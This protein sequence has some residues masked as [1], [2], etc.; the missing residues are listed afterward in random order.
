MWPK[1][2]QTALC[3]QALAMVTVLGDWKFVCMACGCVICIH[4]HM[5]MYEHSTH[6]QAHTHTHSV[7]CIH[8]HMH[9]YEHSTHAQTH[10][11]C[12]CVYTHAHVWTLNSR[13]NTHTH[14]VWCVYTCTCMNTQLA[15]RHT[16]I[17]T[18]SMELSHS[19]EINRS[20]FACKLCIYHG[21][22][23][24]VTVCTLSHHLSLHT[25]KSM[26]ISLRSAATLSSLLCLDLPGGFFLSG[27]HTKILV[28]ISPPYTLH[29]PLI[30]T[31]FTCSP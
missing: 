5:H 11:Q 29:A 15:H 16:H 7:M 26:P 10:T 19:W 12:V 25:A 21:N 9:V 17:C 13:T 30:T 27:V 14:S 28:R 2:L 3:V 31:C 20:K 23:R 22:H 4:I 1:V 6:T 8:M 24:F 18:N